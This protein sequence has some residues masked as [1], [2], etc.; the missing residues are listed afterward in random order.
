MVVGPDG[1]LYVGELLVLELDTEGLNDPGL[2][3]GHPAPGAIIR[4]AA[5][6]AK[7]ALASSGLDFPTALVVGRDGYAYVS[8]YGTASAASGH[9]GEIVRVKLG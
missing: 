1:A 2:N 6:G 5:G 7:T 9:G 3:T 8:D 4:I